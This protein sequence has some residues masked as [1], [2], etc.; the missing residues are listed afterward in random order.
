M[1]ERARATRSG[2]AA[3]RGLGDRDIGG[4]LYTGEMYG[5]QVDLL[6]AVLAA[7]LPQARA[8]AGRW[9]RLGDAEAARLGPGPRSVSVTRVGPA[10]GCGPRRS[11]PRCP[12]W[13][14][15]GP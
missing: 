15:S 4:M 12:G 7:S 13:P 14:T 3:P 8:A 2:T 9:R 5:L 11:R 10:A 1:A 6:A